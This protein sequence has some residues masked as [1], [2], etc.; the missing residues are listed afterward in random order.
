MI[1]NI[2]EIDRKMT[3]DIVEIERTAV[4]RKVTTQPE[5]PEKLVR[6]H[7]ERLG[8]QSRLIA[9]GKIPLL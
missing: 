8:R 4:M 6:N 1:S 2:S 7:D 9:N 5:R 3:A